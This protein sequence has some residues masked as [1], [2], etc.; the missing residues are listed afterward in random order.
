MSVDRAI[1]VKMRLG[2]I[3]VRFSELGREWRLPCLLCADD[4][5]LGAESNDDLRVTIGRFAEVCKR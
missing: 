2:R 3:G 1:K 4:L 5:V